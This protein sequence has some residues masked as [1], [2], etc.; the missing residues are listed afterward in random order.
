MPQTPWCEPSAISGSVER[1]S[2]ASCRFSSRRAVYYRLRYSGLQPAQFTVLCRASSWRQSAPLAGAVIAFFLSRSIALPTDDRAV[3]SH[4]PAAPRLR[5]RDCAGRVATGVPAASLADH[6]LLCHQLHARSVFDRSARLHHRHARFVAGPLRLCILRY[7]SRC[8]PVCVDDR[9]RST[10]LDSA[11]HWGRG[12]VGF[13]RSL[14]PCLKENRGSDRKRS[15]WL[16]AG[17]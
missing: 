3:D 6:T 7:S 8:E 2:S 10:S 14:R 15:R 5:R 1:S 16:V 11:W 17:L 13:D 9:R 4:P 12:D